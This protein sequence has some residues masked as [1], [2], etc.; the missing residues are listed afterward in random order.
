MPRLSTGGGIYW[1][2][3]RSLG[4]HEKGCDS[5]ALTGFA[6]QIKGGKNI[7][8]FG[9]Y[10]H[11]IDEKGRIRIPARLKA[12][13]G[14]DFKVTKGTSGCIF[15]FKELP[16]KFGEVP[17]SDL[18]AQRSL[19]LFYSSVN[20]LEQDNQGRYLMPRNLREFANIKKD[21][22]FIG[23]GNRAEVWAREEYEKYLNGIHDVNSVKL[24]DFDKA[25]AG[26][27]KYGV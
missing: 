9:E 16:A 12:A 7:V 23:V 19:R 10:H 3:R 21:I 5:V 14:E 22:V 1:G 20:E 8:L 26:L 17:L 27:Q 18:D 4:G 24:P 11:Q 15:L 6:S 25:I 13:L 2:N